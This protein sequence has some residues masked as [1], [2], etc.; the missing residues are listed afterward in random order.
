MRDEKQ[1][2]KYTW[3]QYLSHCKRLCPKDLSFDILTML[4]P[5]YQAYT[6]GVP[7]RRLMCEIEH[8]ASLDW[9]TI[10]QR[11]ERISAV[12]SNQ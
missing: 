6:N 7:H 8:V 1:T 2:N 10:E 12:I 5:F 4:V 3:K 9:L 11:Q